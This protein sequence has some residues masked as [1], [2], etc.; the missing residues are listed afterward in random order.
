M[1]PVEGDEA[2]LVA[3]DGVESVMDKKATFEVPPVGAGLTTV[4]DPVPAA[5]ISAAV[6]EAVS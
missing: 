2:S 1:L 5:A 6:M 3:T 4:T